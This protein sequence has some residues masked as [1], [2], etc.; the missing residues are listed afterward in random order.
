MLGSGELRTR[1]NNRGQNPG[2][3]ACAGDDV[4][5]L[6][7]RGRDA[8]FFDGPSVRCGLGPLGCLGALPSASSCVVCAVCEQK[9]YQKAMGFGKNQFGS[10]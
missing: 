2:L 3:S 4:A 10:S 8:I 1:A 7:L 6:C 9:S 5:S